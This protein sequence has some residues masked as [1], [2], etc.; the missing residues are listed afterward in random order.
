MPLRLF[1][2]IRIEQLDEYR[3]I[4]VAVV[5]EMY[6]RTPSG[7]GGS[8]MAAAYRS[9]ASLVGRAIHMRFNR[10]AGPQPLDILLSCVNG[11]STSF[12]E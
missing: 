12:V 6:R 4:W 5:E 3:A 9:L 11:Y 1:P 7:G 10:H 8:P 2:V